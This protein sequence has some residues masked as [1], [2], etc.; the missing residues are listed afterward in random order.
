MLT[1]DYDLLAVKEEE[2]ILDV[3]CGEGRHSHEAYRRHCR[4]YAV[5]VDEAALSSTSGLF[6]VLEEH[7][8]S[9]GLWAALRASANRLPFG[10]ASFDK[11]VCS[12][13]LEHLPDD[14]QAAV[15]LFRVLKDRGRLAVSV[16][17]F[18]SETVYWGLSSKYRSQPGGHVRKYRK[19]E[20]ISLLKRNGFEVYA[21]RRKHALHFFYWMLRCLFGINREKAFFPSL[22]YR[23]LVWD[24][25]KKKRPIRLLEK[26]LNP[27]LA[28]SMVIYAR[29]G[30]MEHNGG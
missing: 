2:D 30:R 21:I 26:M 28:K 29:K 14:E 13:V 27:F 15:E 11:I 1:I 4:V 3:G 22:Y 17:T 23:F 12:E 19:G 6:R 24:I 25:T 9:H 5:D 16:P 10:D 7:E 20:V 8:P 18:L